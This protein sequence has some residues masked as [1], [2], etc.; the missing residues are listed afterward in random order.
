MPP[1][2][3]PIARHGCLQTASECE[4]SGFTTPVRAQTR[5]LRRD[6]AE[7][8][9]PTT[10]VP[11]PGPGPGPGPHFYE[12]GATRR[13]EVRTTHLRGREGRVSTEPARSVGIHDTRER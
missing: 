7:A 6:D 11:V 3:A 13:P 4:V 10:R 5:H 9:G 8:D 2:R 12:T 1:V